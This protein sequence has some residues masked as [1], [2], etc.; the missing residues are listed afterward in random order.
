MNHYDVAIVGAG[1]AGMAVAKTLDPGLKFVLIDKGLGVGERTSITSGFGG[2]GLF[3]DGKLIMSDTVGG[4]IK[5]YTDKPYYYLEQAAYMFGVKGAPYTKVYLD[6]KK[7]ALVDKASKVGLELIATNTIHLGTDGCKKVTEQIYEE[8]GQKCEILV[9]NSVTDIIENRE[10][11]EFYITA[12]KFPIYCKYLVLAPGREGA[13]WLS[14][15][16]KKVN[17]K[18]GGNKVDLGLR[19]EVPNAVAKDLVEFAHDFKAHYYTKAFDD[20][21][22]TFCTCP[23]GQVVREQFDDLTTCNGH[24]FSTGK[25]HYTN[26][27]LLVSIPFGDPINPNEFGRSIVSLA[28]NIAEGGVV[29]QRLG[30]LLAGRRSTASRIAK[31]VTKPTL[32]AFPG[33]LSLV[34]PYRYLSDIVE[35]IEKLDNIA[36]G[37]MASGNL[38]YGVEAKFYSNVI[39]LNNMETSVPNLFCVGDGSGVSRGIVQAVA[40]GI[41]AGDTINKKAGVK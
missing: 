40:S 2:A 34:L 37:M 24:S 1:P 7:Q 27:A 13:K 4:N 11:E 33:D 6:D 15:I 38:L 30:D 17:V 39:E 28:N 22:R 14:E 12:K 35:M 18:V 32:D 8:L 25:T 5:D 41:I 29:V 36:P 10:D 19:M 23:S 26:F 21:V 16:L 9:D 31:S 20:L 3:S